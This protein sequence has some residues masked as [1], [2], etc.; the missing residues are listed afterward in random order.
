MISPNTR[1]DGLEEPKGGLLMVNRPKNLLTLVAVGDNSPSRDDPPSVF[2]FSGDV[3]RTADIA[4]GQ[5]E[6]PLSDT[7]MPMFGFY[8]ASRL[9]AKNISTLTEE[10]AGFDVMSFACNHAVDCGW[11]A[12]R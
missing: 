1:N 8:A 2:R 6:A 3:L 4:F 11:E 9:K 10:G 5:M 12:F 7:G